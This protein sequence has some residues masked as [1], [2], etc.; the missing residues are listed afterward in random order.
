MNYLIDYSN[1]RNAIESN[2]K[3]GD[4]LLKPLDLLIKRFRFKN[5]FDE[6]SHQDPFDFIEF[7]TVS[8]EKHHLFRNNFGTELKRLESIVSIKDQNKSF[9]EQEMKTN[10]DKEINYNKSD[11]Q[12]Q[13]RIN[14][15][16]QMDIEEYDKLFDSY[17]PILKDISFFVE[18][19]H[20]CSTCNKWLTTP[21]EIDSND[22]LSIKKLVTLYLN[23]ND[24]GESDCHNY[25]NSQ[26][27]PVRHLV[28]YL[29][30]SKGRRK[31]AFINSLKIMY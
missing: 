10:N 4:L 30:A 8:I 2:D 12:N 5:N 29:R 6:G 1:L 21:L 19:I 15:K 7:L 24:G 18:S 3:G 14:N 17:P 28:T 16:I 23:K 26:V 11:E 9:N 20:N 27:C 22:K 31:P 13:I 25:N